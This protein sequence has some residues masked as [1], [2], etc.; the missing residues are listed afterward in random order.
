MVNVAT[1]LSFSRLVSA[2]TA[3]AFLVIVLGAYVRLTDAGL[4][5]PDWPGCYGQYGVPQ[6]AATIDKAQ[7]DFPGWRV[8]VGKAWRE[9]LHRYIAG[10]LG[11]L[12]LA[13]TIM[14][15]WIRHPRRKLS[16]G[17]LLLVVFQAVL[18]MWTVTLLLQPIVVVAHLA[19]GFAVL[20]MLWWMVLD[21]WLLAERQSSATKLSSAVLIGLLLLI[22]QLLLGGWTSANYAALA[23]PD[24]PLCHGQWWPEANFS[25][26][27]QYLS[28]GPNYQY[29]V[30]DS[31]TRTAIHISHRLGAVLLTAYFTILLLTIFVKQRA[32]KIRRVVLTTAI[33]F[34][35]QL[36]LGIANVIFS[37]P[38]VTAIL[39]NSVAAILLLS[40]LLLLRVLKSPENRYG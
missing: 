24:F 20:A 26:A 32:R 21:N 7:K 34:I 3:L 22:A 28:I 29:G 23:C 19:G 12:I 17:L 18:G 5:C 4:G 39:H 11:L 38:L 33:I 30:L 25:D 15:F 2:T 13:M 1:H 31:P 14:A 27:F 35:C 9:M 37:L 10:I 40:S 8:E 6:D 36:L 16:L